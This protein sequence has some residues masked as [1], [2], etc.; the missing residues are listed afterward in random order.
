ME[1]PIRD[2]LDILLQYH[3]EQVRVIV[4]SE[5]NEWAAKYH[6]GAARELLS[7]FMD[8]IPTGNVDAEAIVSH[9]FDYIN[10]QYGKVM[11]TDSHWRPRKEG[12]DG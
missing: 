1:I 7:R 3:A 2:A 12:V 5:D 10:N 8:Y 6:A 11:F 4:E 9:T